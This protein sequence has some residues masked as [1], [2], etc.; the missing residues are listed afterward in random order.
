MPSLVLITGER[1]LEMLSRYEENAYLWQMMKVAKHTTAEL[2]EIQGFNHGEGRD[3][4]DEALLAQ[5]KRSSA[6]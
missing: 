6:D 2:H 4:V 1:E 5:V 3:Q